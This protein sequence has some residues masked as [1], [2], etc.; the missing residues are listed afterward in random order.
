MNWFIVEKPAERPEVVSHYSHWKE[1]LAVE[2]RY[3]CVYCAIAEASFG[4]RRNFHVEH[5][6]PKSKF[7][8][9][10]LDYFNLFYA[11]AICNTFK[12]NDW[13]SEPV[14]DHT[15]ATYPMPSAVDYSSLMVMDTDYTL[16]GCCTAGTYLV[17][18]LALNRAQLVRERRMFVLLRRMDNLRESGFGALEQSLG[19]DDEAV[20]LN[21]R[22]VLT[23]LRELMAAREELR[24]SRPYGADE[25]GRAGE[26]DE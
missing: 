19:D 11:C 25:A 16:R 12:G 20:Q 1:A 6:R 3:Q 4:G 14:H 21:G 10:L 15:V 9:L 7:P 18:R 23:A 22:A 8:D 17:W 26:E 2:G 5:F 24:S 13:P